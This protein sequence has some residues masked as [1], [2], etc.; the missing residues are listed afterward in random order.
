[1]QCCGGRQICFRCDLAMTVSSLILKLHGQPARMR[2]T[3]AMASSR[4]MRGSRGFA[5]LVPQRLGHGATGGKYI[6]DQGGC[7]EADYAQAG[8]ST[9]PRGDARIDRRTAGA[10]CAHDRTAAG[11]DLASRG[12]LRDELQQ[13]LERLPVDQRA[14]LLLHADGFRYAE[15]ANILGCSL[16]A[17]KLRIFRGRE[18]CLELYRT[19]EG[20]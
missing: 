18:R 6:E 9:A 11:P 1:M 15:I 4:R 19:G 12:A 16:G 17:V 7:N 3:P 14:C 13:I 8:R 10:A 2:S 5:V 20:K